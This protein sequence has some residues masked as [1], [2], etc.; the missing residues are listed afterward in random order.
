MFNNTYF[1]GHW[2]LIHIVAK[3]NKKEMFAPCYQNREHYL[4]WWGSGCILFFP[5][6]SVIVPFLWCLPLARLSTPINL[7]PIISFPITSY[8]KLNTNLSVL[9]PF[10]ILLHGGWSHPVQGIWS[11]F[12]TSPT[13][14]QDTHISSNPCYLF[15]LFY[16]QITTQHFPIFVLCQLPE[17]QLHTLKFTR[18]LS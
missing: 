2:H 18:M 5:H 1:S 13:H 14:H 16:W 3:R 7:F 10:T 12:F 9:F 6:Y 15:L 4:N 11:A 8:S 17:F